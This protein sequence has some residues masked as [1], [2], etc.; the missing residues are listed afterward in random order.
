MKSLKEI[1]RE[2]D[3]VKLFLAVFFSELGGYLT[4]TVILF[5]VNEVTRGSKMYL[6]LTQ[7]L[8]VG[9]LALGTLV[10]GSLGESSNKRNVMIACEVSNLA[11]IASMLFVD[12]V[13]PIILIRA[14]IVFFA[15]L[16]NPNRMAIMQEL[17]APQNVRTMNGAFTTIF[18]LLHSIG[19]WLGALAYK[20][21][22]G[23]KE[24]LVF[25]IVTY[26]IGAM[27]V[28][29]LNYRTEPLG[30]F[31]IT[32]RKIAADVHEGLRYITSRGDLN[33]LLKNV[34]IG[35]I[36]LGVFYPT[37]LPFIAETFK[38]DETT[39]GH[40]MLAFGLG[41]VLGGLFSPL[42]L[43][44]VPKGKILVTFS[45]LQAATLL[46]WT[47]ISNIYT[48]CAL[49]LVWGAG[50][51]ALVSTYIN[52]VQVNVATNY[53]T[54]AFSIYDQSISLNV[55]FGAAI[56]ALVGDHLSAYQ[57]LSY[58]ALGALLVFIVRFWSSG[59]RALYTM[60]T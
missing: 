2:K 54:R 56:V 37:L 50:M 58:T 34:S 44:K 59:M 16:Y 20:Q 47:Q 28:Y 27:F 51:M 17:V 36:C 52:Y 8:F 60:E 25:N 42:L 33:A 6:G 23:I 40:L 38:G 15:G 10:G 5:Y 19:P 21:F 46:L 43:R 31:R 18:A 29:L 57:L 41:G 48:S 24:V 11:L 49:L 1:L 13:L 53:R 35:G 9:P 7:L 12:Q 30:S 22:G 32:P 4:N 3:F 14:L 45:V 39:Y 55:V 26:F